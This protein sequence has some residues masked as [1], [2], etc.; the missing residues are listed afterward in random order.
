MLSP[1]IAGTSFLLFVFLYLEMMQ[2]HRN[3]AEIEEEV[4]EVHMDAVSAGF[5][6]VSRRI[7]H[8]H[9]YSLTQN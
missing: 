4:K 5:E 3:D 7:T 1:I 2:R 6:V 9:F 8:P